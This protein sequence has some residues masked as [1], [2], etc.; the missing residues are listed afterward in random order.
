MYAFIKLNIN[1]YVYL[2]LIYESIYVMLVTNKVNICRDKL[3]SQNDSKH[4]QLRTLMVNVRVI[5][6]IYIYIC[7][8]H[9]KYFY[10]T[11]KAI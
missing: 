10:D 9:V 4:K 11:Q 2:Y 8:M 6:Y 3:D 7:N 5:K 1:L